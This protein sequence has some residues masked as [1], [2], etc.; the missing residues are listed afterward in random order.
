[1]LSKCRFNIFKLFIFSYIGL[2]TICLCKIKCIHK[3]K[4]TNKNPLYI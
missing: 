4:I 2:Y 1:M 3:Q